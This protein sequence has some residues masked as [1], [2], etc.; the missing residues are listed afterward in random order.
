MA[1]TRTQQA[2]RRHIDRRPGFVAGGVGLGA[3]TDGCRD[4]LGSTSVRR[5]EVS[6]RARLATPWC[7]RRTAYHSDRTPTAISATIR[8][9]VG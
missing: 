7:L 3:G 9:G 8:S 5:T 1:G 4:D 6:G 2:R